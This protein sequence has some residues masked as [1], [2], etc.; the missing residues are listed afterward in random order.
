VARHRNQNPYYRYNLA[1]E[2]YSVQ[3]Y[4]TAIGHLKYAVRKEKNEDQFYFLL[5]MSHLQKGDERTARRWLARAEEVAAT[6]ALKRRYSSKID[7]LRA[8]PR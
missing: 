4:D 5:G 2:A 6:D 8:I 7:R 1:R 3:D